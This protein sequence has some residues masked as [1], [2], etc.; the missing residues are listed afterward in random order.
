MASESSGTSLRRSSRRRQTDGDASDSSEAS[1]HSAPDIGQP[2]TNSSMAFPYQDESTVAMRLNP[3]LNPNRNSREERPRPSSHG[4]SAAQPVDSGAAPGSFVSQLAPP[5][6]LMYTPLPPAA[7]DSRRTPLQEVAA[8]HGPAQ[9]TLP[10]A[11]RLQHLSDIFDDLRRAHSPET[12]AQVVASLTGVQP[13][14]PSA[15]RHHPPG[16]DQ[17][18][19]HN[20][21][22]SSPSRSPSG[23]DSEITFLEPQ[24]LSP[25]MQQ[26]EDHN[27]PHPTPPPTQPSRSCSGWGCLTR[28]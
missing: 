9:S 13:T 12:F 25:R 23:D 3:E 20:V 18:V 21:S 1:Y 28:L 15:R 4:P 24:R 8:T 11:E 5:S 16:S 14:P 7:Q 10:S 26:Q 22:S 2:R 19:Y 17:T 6:Q 27:S